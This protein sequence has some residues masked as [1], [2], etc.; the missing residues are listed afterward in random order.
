MKYK[1]IIHS[2]N[3]FIQKRVAR[4]N[5]QKFESALAKV[6]H[7][8]LAGY[9]RPPASLLKVKS[10]T[11]Q[12]SNFTSRWDGEGGEQVREAVVRGKLVVGKP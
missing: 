9:D 3:D 10:R 8:E 11:S 2:L 12:K 4:V 6:P 5:K 1:A 7:G